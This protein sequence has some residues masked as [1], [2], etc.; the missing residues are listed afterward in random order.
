[1]KAR[2]DAPSHAAALEA[3]TDSTWPSVG[4]PDT[5]GSVVARGAITVPDVLQPYMGG[6]K[7]IERDK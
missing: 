5:D 7:T 2:P 1:M 6:L 4:V 3:A